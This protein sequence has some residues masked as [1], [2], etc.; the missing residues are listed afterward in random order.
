MTPIIILLV[1]EVN[2]GGMENGAMYLFFRI[3]LQVIFIA[4]AYYFGIHKKG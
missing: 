2:L 4:W 1:K 3:P